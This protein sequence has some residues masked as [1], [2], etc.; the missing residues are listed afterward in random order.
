MQYLQARR[1]LANGWRLNMPYMEKDACCLCLQCGHAR[2]VTRSRHLI[3]D[4][5]GNV[6]LQARPVPY[7]FTRLHQRF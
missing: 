2:A 6:Q 4:R 1:S 5:L 7:N 3:D